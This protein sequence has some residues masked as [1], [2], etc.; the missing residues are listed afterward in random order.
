MKKIA[1][2]TYIVSALTLLSSLATAY[3]HGAE[4]HATS[5][6]G[7]AFRTAAVSMPDSYSADAAQAI[8]ARGGNA[9]DAA[10][11][12]TFVLAVTFP[13]AG[14][15]GGGGFMMSYMDGEA[16]FLDFR[17]RAPLSASRDMYLDNNGNVDSDAAT[18]GAL[19]VGVP[20]TVRGMEMAHQRYG[21]LPWAEL[22]QP[23]I[24]L[25]EQG[26]TVHP[27]LAEVALERMNEVE[28][29]ANLADHFGDMKA[30]SVFKQ[31]ELAATL[32]RIAADPEDFYQGKTAK[33]L[34]QQMERSGGI[35]TQQDLDAY[36]ALWRAPLKSS[37]REF[38]VLAAPPPSSGGFALIQLLTLRDL[39]QPYFDGLEH[40]SPQY[41]HL[42]SEIEKR[43]FAD[44]AKYLGDA[45]YVDVPM[46]DLLA[47]AYLQ[48]RAK[49]INPSAISPAATVRPGLEPTETTHFSI[50][51]HAG[52]A[53]AITYT[54]NWDFGSGL[55][56]EGAGF[57]L[58]DEM[59]DFSAKP[60]VKN[61]YGV[62]GGSR[63]AIEPGKRM[64][65]SMSP[66]ILLKDAQP[67]LILGTPGGSTIFTSV[68]QTI[69][70]IY[71]FN[72]S[73]D[74]AVNATRFHHQLPDALLIRHD[75]RAIP[76]N[77]QTTLEAMGYTVEPNS[78]GN[79]GRVQA[80]EVDGKAVS[81]A[82]DKRGWG[83]ARVLPL[84]H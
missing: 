26:F 84:T 10:I 30:N 44:R 16:A 82:T 27:G 43:V 57:L 56:V 21:T 46:G 65:S 20:G 29:L 52:N 22:L 70:N 37:W 64:L 15:I 38:T 51:D 45:D 80:I 34:L 35:I 42:L 36:R 28:G 11:S 59:D 40:N 3:V 66:T 9:V 72:M 39:A 41:L 12:A 49:E 75:Q 76:A 2:L 31:A 6:V 48:K 18:A 25:A 58:N 14:N 54:L 53:V 61:L 60:G 73:V 24:D 50:L 5:S 19:S 17:E 55:V 67:A 83:D 7:T 8:L 13:R 69:L 33:Y 32:T 74:A 79:L 62:I 63:N 78:W 81:T 71:D 1:S 4:T 23:A 77:T 47:P 68:F